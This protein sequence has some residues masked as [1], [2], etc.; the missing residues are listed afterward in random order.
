MFKADFISDKHKNELSVGLNIA[1]S[2]K[3][4]F[5]SLSFDFL[6]YTYHFNIAWESKNV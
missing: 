6:K 1:Y 4:C 5:F 2:K 3:W